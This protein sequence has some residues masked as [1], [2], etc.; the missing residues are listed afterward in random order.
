MHVLAMFAFDNAT[1]LWNECT[2]KFGA[3]Q[4]ESVDGSKETLTITVSYVAEDIEEAYTISKGLDVR[5]SSVGVVGTD[6]NVAESCTCGDTES[7]SLSHGGY[8]RNS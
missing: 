2:S 1:L 6:P 8:G 3:D 5:I 4:A 7:G